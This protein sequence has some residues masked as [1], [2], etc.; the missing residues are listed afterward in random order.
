M[1][2]FIVTGTNTQ[3]AYRQCVDGAPGAKLDKVLEIYR[4]QAAV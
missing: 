3:T 4:N 2:S 1:Q